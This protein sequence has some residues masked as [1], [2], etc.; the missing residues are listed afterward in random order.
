M[1]SFCVH[2]AFRV[3]QQVVEAIEITLERKGREEEGLP[4][5]RA[6]DGLEM[7][8]LAEGRPDPED[9]VFLRAFQSYSWNTDHREDLSRLR[10]FPP[11]E[12]WFLKLL[13]E[14]S[15]DPVFHYDRDYVIW[16]GE[17]VLSP[18]EA[19]NRTEGALLLTSTVPLVLQGRRMAVLASFFDQGVLEMLFREGR[20]GLDREIIDTL[21]P[22]ASLVKKHFGVSLPTIEEVSDVVV[23]MSLRELQ[24]GFFEVAS[25]I[26][27]ERQRFPF[28]YEEVDRTVSRRQR[29]LLGEG[30]RVFFLSPG[31]KGYEKLSFVAAQTLQSF[32]RFLG[33]VNG[34][35]VVT[36]DMKALFDDY[37]ER[38]APWVVFVS[39]WKKIPS[40]RVTTRVETTGQIDWL[41]VNF[42]VEVEGGFL[43][44]EEWT[45]L[46]RY[47][48]F[49]REGSVYSLPAEQRK[50]LQQVEE[51]WFLVSEDGKRRMRPSHVF[52]L[53]DLVG[54]GRGVFDLE[55]SLPE[56]YRNIA[57]AGEVLDT[58]IPIPQPIASF[59]RPYQRIGFW[60]LH[61][62]YRF[63]FG[64]FLADEMGL[65]KTVQAIAFVLSMKHEGQTIIVCPS[66]LMHNWAKEIAKFAG[67]ALR[68][69]VMDGPQEKRRAKQHQSEAYDVLITS[70]SLLH[71]DRAFY[72]G[73]EFHLCILDEAQHVKNKKAKRT[74]SL[75][76]LR[77]HHRLA[78]TGTPIENSIAEMWTV[79]DFLMPGF[80][81]SYSWFSKT[82]ETP[83]Q[84]GS[85]RQ[86][87]EVYARLKRLTSP[88]VLRRTKSE[89][90]SDLP[91]KIEQEVWLDLSEGQKRVYLEM[92]E[93]IR[94]ACE[95]Q[96]SLHSGR[97]MAHFL[98]GLTRLRQIC[99]H[100]LLAGYAVDDEPIKL[101]ALRELVLEALDS[102]HRVVIF[103]QFVELLHIV[104]Q[105]LEGMGIEVLSLDGRTKNRVALVDTFNEGDTP[106]FL[107]STRAGGTG[108]TITGA[109]TV[110]LLD[111]WWNPS[112]EK[113]AIDRVHRI[114]QKQTVHVFRLFTEGT[115]EEKMFL[116]QQRKK[117]V[118]QALITSNTAFLRHLSWED[119]FSLLQTPSQGT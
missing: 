36:H 89:V 116:L 118:F 56:K 62:L 43:T 44:P 54:E 9:Y 20:V 61:F 38:V 21:L 99:L 119:L 24:E 94:L 53:R 74:Q 45:H 110:I 72:H 98:A 16:R 117:D 8:F 46:V 92:V 115:I 17:I 47:G 31:E 76:A 108:L 96:L 75:K 3:H 84:S 1:K 6:H 41:E 5:V 97:A 32:S 111:P 14:Y 28:W 40:A 82:F 83:L 58:S 22:R 51:A 113:Q 13:C 80:L 78:I 27:I 87:E 50:W 95:R 23:E 37:L 70:Y 102:R 11:F 48:Y 39:A 19:R 103:S 88:F 35:T 65:G 91:P 33:E 15:A 66:A 52:L 2:L 109:D 67:S 90:L 104:R 7:S 4:G 64:G 57:P 18:F 30:E 12:V 107:I 59:L 49:V 34:H 55:F 105:E 63:H 42:C 112:V 10:I 25:W 79:F 106:V 114:G 93:R 71:Q 60:W 69:L 101:R 26:V 29:I 81:G 73:R 77:A 68:V 86:K 100:P 85:P